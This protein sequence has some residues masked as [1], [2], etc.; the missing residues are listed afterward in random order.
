MLE[1]HNDIKRELTINNGCQ[2]IGQEQLHGLAKNLRMVLK[3]EIVVYVI[4]GPF[5]QSPTID[6]FDED[7]RA[8]QKHSDDSEIA[9]CTMFASMSLE[10][11]KQHE[12]MS[13][14]SIVYHL[15]EFFD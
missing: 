9:T 14:H 8:Y 7:Q 3:A 4:D 2:Q 15:S 11:Q 10:L 6:A 1:S 5:P 12:A 13:A